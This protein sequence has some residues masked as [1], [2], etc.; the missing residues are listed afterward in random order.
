MKIIYNTLIIKQRK[1][2][3]FCPHNQNTT[4]YILY[5]K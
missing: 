1:N 5:G 4:F 3:Y 2:I